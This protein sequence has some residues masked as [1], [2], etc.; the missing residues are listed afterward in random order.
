MA[1][2][3]NKKSIAGPFIAIPHAVIETEDYKRLHGNAIK[4]LN[5]LVYQYRGRNNGD[6]TAAYS[7]MQEFGFCSKE[8]LSKAIKALL[9]ANLICKTREG[10]FLNPGGRCALYA[11][12]WRPIDE[13]PGKHLDY[14]PT[15][16][17]PRKFSMEKNR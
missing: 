10:I 1:R 8:T 15:T 12:T 9:D 6:L 17:P 7:Y 14:G 11:L 16:T 3:K 4:L 13:C 5:A 2:P